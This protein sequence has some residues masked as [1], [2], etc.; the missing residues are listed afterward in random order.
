MAQR[1][2]TILDDDID[3]GPA[4]STIQFSYQGTQYEIDL[5]K[6]NEQRL[7]AAL[8]PFT[9]RARRIG[10]GRRSSTK[11]PAGKTD[12]NQL[13]AMRDWA[14]SNG[15]KVSDRGRVS[16]EVQDAYNASR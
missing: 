16:Q 11:A 5:S 10:G 3:G 6:E 13:Q 2:Q 9:S 8:E 4:D 14:R 1:I 7:I 15:L 12:T